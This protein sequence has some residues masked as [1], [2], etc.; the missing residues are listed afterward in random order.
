MLHFV[1]SGPIIRVLAVLFFWATALPFS[2]QAAESPP[3][4]AW[5]P[6]VNLEV[7]AG[8]RGFYA[9]DGEKSRDGESKQRYGFGAGVSDWLFFELEGEYQKP[10]GG[11]LEFQAYELESRIELTRTKAFNEVPNP[12]D[13]GLLFGISVPQNGGD[14]YEAESRLL[15]YKRVGPWRSTGNIVIEKEFGNSRA[16]EVE[17]AYAGQLR[18][19]LTRNIQPGFEAFGRFGAVDDLSISDQ[20]QKIG[21]GVFGFIEIKDDVALKYEVSWLFG[22]TGPT[23][24]H[25]L[26][27]LAEFEYR[28]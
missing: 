21:P 9:F 27:W 11:A 28:Y 13:V 17:L 7:E 8:G 10:P 1:R 24:A 19:R 25:S 14:S 4:R 20:Q 5:W 2:S 3:F 26:K 6:I 22:I 18:Y 16:S 23:P 12:L 15:L